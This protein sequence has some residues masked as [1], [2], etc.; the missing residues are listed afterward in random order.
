[1]N[2][3]K[4]KEIVQKNKICYLVG[5]LTL[6]TLKLFYAEA[7]CEALRWILGPT[8]R[9]VALTT[10][11]SFS[12]EPG[13]GYV[14]HSLK[15]VIAPSCSGV[16][17]MTILI[18][19]LIFSFAHR[20]KRGPCFTFFCLPCS[21]VLTVFV[22]VLRIILSIYV[23]LFFGQKGF[24]SSCLT[25]DTLH[26]VIGTATYFASLLTIYHVADAYFLKSVRPDEGTAAG[27]PASRKKS[28]NFT[29][30]V[31]AFWYFMIVLFLPFLN[32][33]S[34]KGGGKFAEYAALISSV[35]LPILLLFGA[36][37]VVRKLFKL[38]FHSL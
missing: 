21:Y 19:M 10:G 15:Y 8:A 7:S 11:I 2:L 31:P 16:R 3:R 14:N 20:A 25:Q 9:L 23:P 30:L 13:M 35:C 6:L 4:L 38:L 27:R 34:A 37:A 29:Y 17:F 33:A 28:G 5:I 24:Y 26:T 18:A 1:M 32:H 12:Y 22:N 36:A